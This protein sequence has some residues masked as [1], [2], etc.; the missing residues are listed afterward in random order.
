F[1]RIPSLALLPCIVTR[2]RLAPLDNIESVTSTPSMREE[3]ARAA[4]S[5]LS[6]SAKTLFLASGLSARNFCSDPKR[7]EKVSSVL[8]SALRSSLTDCQSTGILTSVP[9]RS[10]MKTL[11]LA[12]LR[13]L[14]PSRRIP[15]RAGL[16]IRYTSI[17]RAHTE[18]SGG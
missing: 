4:I 14:F 8:N 13:E 16:P 1:L 10:K 7:G 12:D 3:V 18:P 17:Y 2:E 9:S 6:I 11:Y 5:L 15:S